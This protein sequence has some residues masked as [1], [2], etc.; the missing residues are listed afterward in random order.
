MKEDDHID[1]EDDDVGLDPLLSLGVGDNDD[2]LDLEV[3]GDKG[4]LNLDLLGR[5]GF[6]NIGGNGNGN[7]IPRPGNGNG[8]GNN[9]K[10]NNGKGNNGGY[11]SHYQP[12]CNKGFKKPHSDHAKKCHAK[13]VNH[14]LAI[15]HS[16]S[17][18]LTIQADAKVGDIANIQL[19]A[20]IEFNSSEGGDN[21]RYFVAP[22]TEPCHDEQLEENEHCTT[23]VRN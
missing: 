13:D 17:A 1:L 18:L 22:E 5:E 16:Q 10:G 7:V 4:L 20:A 11:L 15:C 8:K 19:C 3:G 6:L 14:C 2:I 9:G 23:F 21:C 12:L